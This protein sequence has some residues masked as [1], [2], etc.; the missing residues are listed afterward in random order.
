M[1][2][3]LLKQ[4]LWEILVYQWQ[5]KAANFYI[6]M[7]FEK[8]NDWLWWKTHA[9]ILMYLAN[10]V[11]LILSLNTYRC[12]LFQTSTENLWCCSTASSDHAMQEDSA[13]QYS[14]DMEK[15]WNLQ[16][17]FRYVAFSPSDHYE[18]CFISIIWNRAILQL[19]VQSL[20]RAFCSW[21]S[22]RGSVD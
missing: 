19:A 21:T 10:N 4:D 6:T 15:F 7:Q 12:L 11:N 16:H 20:T 9:T 3:T 22:S 8:I 17:S 18:A 14:M 13:R 1:Y 5:C 2:F